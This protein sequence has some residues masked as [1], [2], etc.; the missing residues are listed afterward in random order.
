MD[1]DS[2]DYTAAITKFQIKISD[3][4]NGYKGNFISIVYEDESEYMCT[5]PKKRLT[6]SGSL[7]MNECRKYDH[8][9]SNKRLT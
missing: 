3:G 2:G 4:P 1:H 8:L 5:I 7:K 6:V 9:N